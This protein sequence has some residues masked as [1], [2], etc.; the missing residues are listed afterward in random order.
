MRLTMKRLGH[1]QRSSDSGEQRQ[2]GD[3]PHGD[4]K[5]K[6]VGDHSGR[7]G[8]NGVSKIAPETVDT[9]RGSA[10]CRWYN[11]RDGGQYDRINHPCTDTEKNQSPRE[12]G[13]GG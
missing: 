7:H 4:G 5:T 10:P 6:L 13:K 3:G 11:V 12:I 9:D 1:S 8:A 2:H